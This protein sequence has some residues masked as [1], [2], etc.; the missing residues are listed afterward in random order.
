[1]NRKGE[2]ERSFT[3]GPLDMTLATG[4]LVFIIG[5]NGSG[6]STFVKV[7]TGLYLPQQGAVRVQRRNHCAYDPGLV[8][9]AF[10]GGFFGLLF[11]QETVG[12]GSFADRQPG[13][14]MVE[15]PAN[16]A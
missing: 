2:G 5:G 14:R 12:T 16:R 3:L 13:R 4:E 9:A 1:M 8:P 11:I 6:K 15:D 7:L 10:C